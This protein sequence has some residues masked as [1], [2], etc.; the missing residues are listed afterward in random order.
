MMDRVMAV[1]GLLMLFA[2]LSVV[3]IFVPHIDLI[4]VVAGCALLASYDVWRGIALR[5]R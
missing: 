3:P 2:F 5:H 4:I 1:T